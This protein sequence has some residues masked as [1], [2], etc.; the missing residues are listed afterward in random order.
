MF[1]ISTKLGNSFAI[2]LIL[3]VKKAYSI[4][5]FLLLISC[6]AFAQKKI[7]NT[8]FKIKGRLVDSLSMRPLEYATM[9]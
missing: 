8:G 7:D 2:N 4:V 5:A 9:E 6:S 3:S 1:K